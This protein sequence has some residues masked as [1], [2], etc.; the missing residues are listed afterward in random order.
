MKKLALPLASLLVSALGFAGVANAHYTIVLDNYGNAGYPT[1]APTSGTITV[2]TK[3]SGVW[4]TVCELHPTTRS[5]GH[6]CW[7]SGGFE[8]DEVEAI[9]V[10]TDSSNGFWLDQISLHANAGIWPEDLKR[11]WGADNSTGWCFSTGAENPSQHCW[12]GWGWQWWWNV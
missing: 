10:R 11:T 7:V 1:W 6:Y 9:A 5:E 12:N 3:I 2:R 8:W 4:A